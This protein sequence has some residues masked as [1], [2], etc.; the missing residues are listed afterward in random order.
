MEKP[1]R[2]IILEGADGTGKSTLAR[3]IQDQTKGSILHATYRADLN[4]FEYH[5][6]LMMAAFAL[7][8]MGETVV[9]DRWAPSERVYSNVFRN[10]ESYQTSV[11]IGESEVAAEDVGIILRW[12]Y[13]HNE[14]AIENHT[15]NKDTR[16]EMY[17][18]MTKVVEEYEDYID[19]SPL[20]WIKYDFNKN[21]KT[22]FTKEL[23]K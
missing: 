10:G 6:T 15:K 2:I 9:L 22:E 19:R 7:A 14:D 12:V 11:L 5:T 20:K 16:D 8:S 17:D 23:L 1:G 18:D 3:E 13:T 21:D 4:M